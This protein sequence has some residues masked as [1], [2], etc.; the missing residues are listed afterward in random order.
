MA[1]IKDDNIDIDAHRPPKEG[2]IPALF[3]KRMEPPLKGPREL[4]IELLDLDPLELPPRTIETE[5]QG[6]K[7]ALEIPEVS[8]QEVHEYPDSPSEPKITFDEARTFV[9]PFLAY[10]RSEKYQP[11]RQISI[12]RL[13]FD[14]KTIW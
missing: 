14:T 12:R 8:P 1:T 11:L 6:H 3:A 5:T 4:L 2:P 13:C 7:T 10:F 9:T